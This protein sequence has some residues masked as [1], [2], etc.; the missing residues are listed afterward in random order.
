MSTVKPASLNFL[1][2]FSPA[3]GVDEASQRNQI[4]F[5]HSAADSAERERS[6]ASQ[7]EDLHEKQ[8]ERLRQ[9]GLAQGLIAF[10]R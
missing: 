4:L 10:A 6:A 8:N 1:T 9:V 5:Y 3:L 2:I 7:Q